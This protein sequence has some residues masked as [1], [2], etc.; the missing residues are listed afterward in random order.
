[1]YMYTELDF[2][3]TMNST[4]SFH[5]AETPPTVVNLQLLTQA[6]LYEKL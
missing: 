4:C 5:S 6:F 2:G 1:M 3:T